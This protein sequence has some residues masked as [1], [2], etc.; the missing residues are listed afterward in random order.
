M[1]RVAPP[2]RPAIRTPP[3]PTHAAERLQ[4]TYQRVPAT[5]GIPGTASHAQSPRRAPHPH[6]MSDSMEADQAALHA[7]SVTSAPRFQEP[8][9]ARRP[10]TRLRAPAMPD[11]TALGQ[12]APR[13]RHAIKTP[14][15][16][17]PAPE[18]TI[19]QHVPATQGT[20]G[21]AS[22]AQSARPATRMRS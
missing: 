2:A 18:P 1:A 11:T 3:C 13:A 20:T 15:S 4:P 7:K 21:R 22:R 14:L 9:L 6:A 5:R 19:H 10:M 16:Q 12:A 17:E 8:A